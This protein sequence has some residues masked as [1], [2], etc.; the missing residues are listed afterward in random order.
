MESPYEMI[1]KL[2]EQGHSGRVCTLSVCKGLAQCVGARGSCS[3]ILYCANLLGKAVINFK[4]SGFTDMKRKQGEEQPERY[5]FVVD[6]VLKHPQFT[7][8]EAKFLKQIN[9]DGF[10]NRVTWG[11]LH[12]GLVR[13]ALT[14]LEEP[15]MMTTV[16]GKTFPLL[17]PD[18]K[19]QVRD[20]FEITHRKV[21]AAKQ[22][23]ISELFPSLKT[24]GDAQETVKVTDCTY[25][26]AKK[27]LR[28]LSSLFCLN[29]TGHN[30][31]SISF[32]ELILAALNGSTI[33]WVEEFHQELR[34]EIV[35]L[36][37]K[38]SQ[39]SVKVERT[40]IGP[41]LTL[42][43]KAAGVMNLRHE[44]EA[45]FH[46][47]KTFSTNQPK[48]R[49][50]TVAPRPSPTLHNTV[51]VVKTNLQ[52]GTSTTPPQS[53]TT[54]HT[55]VLETEEPW[56][57]P[58]SLPNLTQQ[59]SQAHRRLENLLTTLASQ[60]PPK[61]MRQVDSQF[62]KIQREAC[63]RDGAQFADDRD[64][65]L[66]AEMFKS[67]S[68]LLE[69][70]EQKLANAEEL[71]DICIENSFELQT[72]LSEMQGANEQLR[73][74]VQSL[75]HK[76]GEILANV[77]TQSLELEAR[78]TQIVALQDQIRVLQQHVD[79][80]NLKITEVQSIQKQEREEI[81][82]LQMEN[83]KLKATLSTPKLSAEF[84]QT[85]T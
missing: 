20:T 29:T 80:Q 84:G 15:T 52:E 19:T 81:T 33:D 13:E 46:V 40:A 28:I 48:K 10:V 76:N 39:G 3:G 37:Q 75:T 45:G 64:S 44:A 21:V 14:N 47:V 67:Q 70:L 1:P 51:K 55:V 2:D 69:R 82:R 25:P 71:N 36:H 23:E 57:V 58:D 8:E 17:A 65:T 49:R 74:E 63:L 16:Q 9:L 66:K 59:I 73:R 41:H 12:E 83:T 30:H 18:W 72:K 22:W 78:N 34:D 38:H 85:S 43:L 4:E 61:L 5:I 32:A 31:I 50:C 24:A 54:T 56:Q 27:P 7:L 77:H 6:V 79:T 53:V 35:K 68:A 60:T 42:I 62:H 11:V 26:G